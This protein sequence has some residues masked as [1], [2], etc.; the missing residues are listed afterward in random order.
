VVLRS[1]LIDPFHSASITVRGVTPRRLEVRLLG[2]TDMAGLAY[3]WTPYRWRPLRLVDGAWHG[4]LSAPALP[5]IYQLQL[6]LDQGRRLVSSNRWL[7]RVFPRGTMARPP[8]SSAVAA[9]R[10]YVAHLPGDQVLVAQRPW[11]QAEF[12]HRDPRLHRIFVIAYAP[13]GDDRPTSRL[14][15][16]VTTVR[17][18]FHGPWR[19]LQ[20]TTQPYG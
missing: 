9:V 10:D 20:A 12:D 7:L 5:G 6:R 17:C 15:L 8:A 11:P 13:R 16:F 14:G 19:V 2:A 4:Q 1:R 3:E 18:G